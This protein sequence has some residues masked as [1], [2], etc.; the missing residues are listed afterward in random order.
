M[1]YEEL[2]EKIVSDEQFKEDYNQLLTIAQYNPDNK[3]LGSEQIKKLLQTASILSLTNKDN[4][5]KI[6]YKIAVFILETQ[7]ENLDEIYKIIQVIFLRL[8]NFPAIQRLIKEEN[9]PDYF[10]LFEEDGI[11]SFNPLIWKEVIHKRTENNF[12]LNDKKFYFTNFQAK[13]FHLLCQKKDVSF[14][15]PTSAGKSFLLSNYSAK[16]ISENEK[17]TIVYVVPSKSLIAQVQKDFQETFH[18]FGIK[19][20]ILLSS[21]PD[22]LELDLNQNKKKVFVLTQERLEMIQANLKDKLLVDLLIIDEA[23]KI[24]DGERGIKL[25]L[26]I[27]DLIDENKEMQKVFISPYTENPEKFKS[28]FTDLEELKIE[29]TSSSPV[30]QNIFLVDFKDKTV[31]ISLTSNELT[32]NLS[33]YSVELN[34]K[35]PDNYK[36][37]IWVLE[38]MTKD[39]SSLIYCDA[40]ID[41]RR[42]AE[43]I[44][45]KRENKTTT[46]NLKE[47]IEF[48]KS[49]VHP[50]YYL[51]DYLK[52]GVGFHY[53]KMPM[54][55]KLYVEDLFKSKDINNIC[56]TSTILEGVNFPAKNI[57]VFKPKSGR[58]KKMEDLTFLNLIGRAGR[59]TKDFYGNIYCIDIE[60]WPSCKDA[61]KGKSQKISSAIDATIE[62]KKEEILKFLKS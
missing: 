61:I 44:S 52:T 32:K 56:C 24:G 6:A 55:V 36:K 1:I 42:A 2:A 21:S 51:L 18:K 20:I 40:P 57:I 25:E 17:Y 45:K 46:D 7:K 58:S 53:S 4:H 13:V 47:A 26:A 48:I 8:G 60:Y 29:S 11:T 31:E 59:L 27:Q 22:I 33:L 41:C 54:F 14:S 38:S 10:S 9:Y 5:Q 39:E 12:E 30:S 28:I 23:H 19:D 49:Q 50:D 43:S 37:K 3:N 34:R 62:N 35:I 15:A 16:S